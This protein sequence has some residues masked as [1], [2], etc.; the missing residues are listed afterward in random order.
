MH[1]AWSGDHVTAR[2]APARPASPRSAA[3]SCSRPARSCS[4]PGEA[5]AT[6]LLYAAYSADGLDGLS[7]ALHTH[8]RA[9]PAHPRT[10]RPVT[11][12]VWEA[13]YFDHDLDR[14]R[15]LA[16]AG[17][18]GRRG[19]LRARRRLVPRPAR[20]PAP[21]SATGTST[22]TSGR[23]GCSRWSTTY[24]G[25]ACSSG[26]GSSRR[27]ST[28]TPTCSAP[29]PTGCSQAPGRLPPPWRHQQ[30]LDLANP[31]AYAYLLERLD[32]LLSEH[33][34]I[35]LP[36]VG[37]QPRPHR[38]RARRPARGARADARGLP[39][40]R[41]AARPAPGRRDRELL[42]RRRPGRPGDP[43]SAPTG[44]GPATATTRWSG[45][46]SSAGPACCCRRS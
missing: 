14:L 38:G 46:A 12:N 21:G 18:R 40:A 41:R 27:W 1:T 19:A 30:V 4:A 24:A 20:R 10:P 35:A 25:R 28:P 34:G 7:D 42:V 13:V 37:P 29:T 11:L 45:C 33:D 16:D 8:L 22:A 15:A 17:R 36:Q 23:T 39:A 26:S 9:R 3:A 31:E 43:A 2:R 5:Y 6:P 44:S 32:A